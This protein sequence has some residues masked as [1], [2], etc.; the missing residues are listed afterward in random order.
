MTGDDL[1]A[2]AEALVGTPFRLHGRDPARGLDCI[3]LLAAGLGT[4]GVDAR[5][6]NHYRLHNR[7]TPDVT[8][9]AAVLGFVRATLPFR[10]GDVVFATPGPLQTHLLIAA[11]DGGFVHA[12]AGLGRVV[13]A[14]LPDEWPVT[15]HWRLSPH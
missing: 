4:C 13:H 2:A 6:P 11:T 7:A 12:H 14:P 10:P 8:P 3:G 15:G 1:A 9:F 5:L